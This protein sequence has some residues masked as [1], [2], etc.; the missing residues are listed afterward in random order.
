MWYMWSCSKL[1]HPIELNHFQF[2]VSH[3]TSSRPTFVE[4]LQIQAHYQEPL[5]LGWENTV[6]RIQKTLASSFSTFFVV[7]FSHKWLG[8]LGLHLLHHGA[9]LRH[10]DSFAFSMT[11]K[12]AHSGAKTSPAEHQAH[13]CCTCHVSSFANDTRDVNW[14]NDDV[15]LLRRRTISAIFFPFPLRPHRGTPVESEIW[16]ASQE[17]VDWWTPEHW[18][19][20][21]VSTAF[22]RSASRR[23]LS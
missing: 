22:S 8:C 6:W 9:L 10:S 21:T 2:K 18:T 23:F 3:W 12:K 20:W 15:K 11:L 17:L 14:W 5:W 19:H 1:K 13:S 4:S 7:S 16:K